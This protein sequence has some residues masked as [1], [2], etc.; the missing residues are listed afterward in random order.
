MKLDYEGRTWQLDIEDVTTRQGEAIW[1]ETGLSILGWWKSLTDADSRVWVKSMRC[2][3]WLMRAQ[4]N[5]PVTLQEA[6]PVPLKLL[7]AFNAGAKA[8]QAPDAEPDPTM[9]GALPDAAPAPD[10][11]SRPG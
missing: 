3:Y 1:D 7:Q 6:D 9:P 5:D 2:L 11:A 4:N 8:E 10:T